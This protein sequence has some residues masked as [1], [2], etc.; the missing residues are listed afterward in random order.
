MALSHPASPP[1]RNGGL[2]GARTWAADEV[3]RKRARAKA[4]TRE[5]ER[6]RKREREKR[7]RITP[8][9]VLTAKTRNWR[10]M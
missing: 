10:T 6:E 5:R 3:A 8:P 1:S 4:R 9:S 2:Q 7:D